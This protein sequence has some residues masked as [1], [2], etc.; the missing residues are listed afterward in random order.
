M[1][2]PSRGFGSA[3]LGDES[4]KCPI[5]AFSAKSPKKPKVTF[6]TERGNHGRMV[7]KYGMGR[8]PRL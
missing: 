5:R 6:H 8:Y 2:A 3:G 4:L 1:L 7:R